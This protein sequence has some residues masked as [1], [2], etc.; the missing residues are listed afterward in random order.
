MSMRSGVAGCG[1]LLAA[2]L[3]VALA[4]ALAGCVVSPY[5]TATAVAADQPTDATEE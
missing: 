2:A 5:P 4:L 3:A 1:G